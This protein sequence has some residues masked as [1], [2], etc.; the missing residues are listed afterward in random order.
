LRRESLKRRQ[1]YGVN[2]AGF[3]ENSGEVFRDSLPTRNLDL[4]KNPMRSLKAEKDLGIL[5]PQEPEEN[6][7]AG[8][9]FFM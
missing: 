3:A 7:A 5:S 1:R 2:P 8:L 4:R 9:A 6:D